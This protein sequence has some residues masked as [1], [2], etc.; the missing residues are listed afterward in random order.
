MPST[1]EPSR[2]F[3]AFSA[4]ARRSKSTNPKPL[5]RL[6][7]RSRT[8]S[9]LATAPKCP[10][11]SFRCPALTFRVSFPTCRRAELRVGLRPRL[12]ECPRLRLLGLWLREPRLRLRLRLRLP[13]AVAA[14]LGGGTFG[15]YSGRLLRASRNVPVVCRRS[16]ELSKTEPRL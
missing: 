7:A 8:T 9:A 12:R 5:D 3:T 2:C 16:G 10:K 1:S 6:T 14:I 13:A 15:G 4:S 11:I